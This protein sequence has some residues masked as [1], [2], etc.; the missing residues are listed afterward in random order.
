ML[1]SSKMLLS[2]LMLLPYIKAEQAEKV[3]EYDLCEGAEP[4]VDKNATISD[5]GLF[6]TGFHATWDSP[7]VSI[8]GHCTMGK[9]VDVLCAQLNIR[10]TLCLKSR[11]RLLAWTWSTVSTYRWLYTQYIPELTNTILDNKTAKYDEVSFEYD[12]D[13]EVCSIWSSSFKTQLDFNGTAKSS[14][15]IGNALGPCSVFMSSLD[16][17]KKI[18][19]FTDPDKL[20][21]GEGK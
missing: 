18:L 19:I 2:C 8:G 6:M 4:N 3:K 13:T 17:A 16:K 9:N 10:L 15:Y 7:P 11:H 1:P 12:Q 14:A 21:E 5:V 20:E